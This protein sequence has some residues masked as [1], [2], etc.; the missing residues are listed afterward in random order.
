[1]IAP[2]PSAGNESQPAIR[3][4]YLVDGNV[5]KEIQPQQNDIMYIRQNTDSGSRYQDGS[6]WGKI[7]IVLSLNCGYIFLK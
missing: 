1:M 6:F 7:L 3:A 4:S 2:G 5:P